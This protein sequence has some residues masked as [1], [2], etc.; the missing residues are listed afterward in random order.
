M[1]R[2][3]IKALTLVSTFTGCS[4]RLVMV[5]IPDRSPWALSTFKR[6]AELGVLVVLPTFCPLHR[7]KY[8]NKI[9]SIFFQSLI[10]RFLMFWYSNTFSFQIFYSCKWNWFTMVFNFPRFLYHFVCTALCLASKCKRAL[11][12]FFPQSS[13]LNHNASP[14]ISINMC[15]SPLDQFVIIGG[16]TR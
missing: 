5:S 1:F 7:C 3:L 14:Q 2:F 8:Q 15:A 11:S 13:T 12:Q 6:R 4:T 9:Y 10:I 16:G